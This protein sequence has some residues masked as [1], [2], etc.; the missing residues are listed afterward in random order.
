MLYTWIFIFWLLI[1][2]CVTLSTAEKFFFVSFLS[3]YQAVSSAA[4]TRNDNM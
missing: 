1:L 4:G 2:N 3:G